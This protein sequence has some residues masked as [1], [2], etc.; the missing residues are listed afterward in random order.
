MILLATC[1][2]F[3]NLTSSNLKRFY[4]AAMPPDD[5]NALFNQGYEQTDQFLNSSK[6]KSILT[7]LPSTSKHSE[8]AAEKT[9]QD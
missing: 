9:S 7:N 8:P 2:H 3:Q 5:L 6:F 1:I 4:E